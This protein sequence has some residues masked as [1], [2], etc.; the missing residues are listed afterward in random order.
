MSKTIF[1]NQS[2]AICLAMFLQ[3]FLFGCVAIFAIH[4]ESIGSESDFETY[5][6]LFYSS[7]LR[8][9]CEQ[10]NKQFE[11]GK[12]LYTKVWNCLCVCITICFDGL[13]LYVGRQKTKY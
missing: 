2:V 5:C 1:I 8:T 9:A 10:S 12:V 7:E 11:D 3:A 13:V 6:G 4:I